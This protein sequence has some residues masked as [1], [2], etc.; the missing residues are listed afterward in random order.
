MEVARALA[1]DDRGL[2]P[3]VA[4]DRLSGEVRMVGYA[5]AEAVR[6]TLETGRATFFSRSRGVLWIKGATSGNEMTVHEVLV[7]C[8]ADTLLYLVS[9]RGPTCHTGARSCFFRRALAREGVVSISDEPVA[10]TTFLARLEHVL[11]ARKTATARKSYTKSL[12]D[13]GSALLGAKLRE[14]AGE[15]A[16]ALSSEEDARVVSE[17]ADVLFHLMVALRARGLS[18][19]DVLAELDRRAGTSGHDEKRGRS[20]GGAEPRK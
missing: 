6:V 8:D 20:A 5:N 14:E 2:L 18:A 3:V 7:D 10:T 9:P 1:F 12:Y 15:L 16:E 13:G 17:A 4:Q 11:E 19:G